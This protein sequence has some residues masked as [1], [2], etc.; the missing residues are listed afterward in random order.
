MLSVFWRALPVYVLIL[1]LTY[2]YTTTLQFAKRLFLNESWY[3]NILQ[4][5]GKVE[6]D[7]IKSTAIWLFSTSLGSTFGLEQARLRVGK[8]ARGIF[9]N[10]GRARHTCVDSGS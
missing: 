3:T 1:R 9:E 8:E 6:L 4:T 2:G 10:E 5:I 7:V